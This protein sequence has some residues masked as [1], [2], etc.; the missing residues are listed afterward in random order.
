MAAF[1]GRLDED[2]MDQLEQWIGTGPKT[3]TLLYCATRDGCAADAFHKNCDSQ[4]AT[5]T[6]LYNPDGS[7]YG[8]YTGQA[9]NGALN[10]YVTDASAFLYQLKFSGFLQCTKFPIINGNNAQYSNATY[11]PTFG[12][13]HELNTFQGTINPSAGVYALNGG[14]K[15]INTLYQISNMSANVKSWNDINNGNMR[16]TDI[17]V[18]KV[19]SKITFVIYVLV[20]KDLEV[21]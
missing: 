7:V 9:W 19:A 16:V 20:L 17:E 15:L 3:F 4:G 6:V 11:G 8:G 21:V 10:G 12:N 2:D 13:G 14:V 18:Y 5:V 1:K